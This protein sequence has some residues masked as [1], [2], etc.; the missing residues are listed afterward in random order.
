MYAIERGWPSIHV[1]HTSFAYYLSM[2]GKTE[3]LRTKAKEL[4]EEY[5]RVE[6]HEMSPRFMGTVGYRVTDELRPLIEQYI[7]SLISQRYTDFE[8]RY[9]YYCLG[10]SAVY[11]FLKDNANDTIKHYNTWAMKIF[12]P[13]LMMYYNPYLFI[14][15]TNEVFA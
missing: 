12:L 1:Y 7:L 13:R 15:N 2:Y 4:Y 11:I 3:E 10:M 14:K 6:S 9:I 8:R 5:D